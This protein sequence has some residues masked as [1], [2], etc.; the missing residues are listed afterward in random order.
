MNTRC[1]TCLST[2]IHWECHTTSNSPVVDGRLR[3]HEVQ[4][5][6]YLACDNCSDTI[7]T[8]DSDAMAESLNRL[9]HLT[10]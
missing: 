10:K 2:D 9:L 7:E 4:A 1:P 8:M 3:M 5:G 6:A